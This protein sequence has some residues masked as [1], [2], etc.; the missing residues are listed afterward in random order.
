MLRAQG[1]RGETKKSFLLLDYFSHDAEINLKNAIVILDP[2]NQSNS[3]SY[4]H[5]LAQ[6][7]V[8]YDRPT[9]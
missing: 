6:A 5:P 8:R 3:E 1:P 2:W 7:P 4:E 9:T